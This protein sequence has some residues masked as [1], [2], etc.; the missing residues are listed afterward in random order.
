MTLNEIVQDILEITS[1]PDKE[2]VIRRNVRASI[3]EVHSAG[4]Y[5]RDRIEE[6]FALNEPT[7][8]IKLTLPP[9]FKR[10]IVLGGV[11]TD[12]QPV[13]LT[14]DNNMYSRIDPAGLFSELASAKV[15]VY[16]VAGAV[17]N[18]RSSVAVHSIYAIYLAHPEVADNE[19][20]TW[21]MAQQS[22]L[23]TDLTLSK[24]LGLFGR[25]KQGQAARANWLVAMQEF[26][27]INI[28]E[29]DD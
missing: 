10:F 26:V 18:I 25:E 14:T 20:E 13:T 7:N 11:T 9:R 1:R 12:G 4:A 6:V 15:D 19:L 8:L 17:F 3:T 22:S 5:P 16:Y 28:V 21:I 24:V 27:A 29:G 23:I 2:D